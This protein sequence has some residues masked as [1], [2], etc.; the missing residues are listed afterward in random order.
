MSKLQMTDMLKL[1]I[2]NID[3][4]LDKVEEIEYRI[5]LIKEKGETVR[6]L[7]DLADDFI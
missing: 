5:E 3:N 6:K 4:E 1:H 2:R 7:T